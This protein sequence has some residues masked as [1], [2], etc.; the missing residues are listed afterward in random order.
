MTIAPSA[1]MDEL[2]KRSRARTARRPQSP[3]DYLAAM[4]A[5]LARLPL[6]K[7]MAIL[8]EAIRRVDRSVEAVRNWAAGGGDL[9]S[10]S[11]FTLHQ[12]YM[13]ALEFSRRLAAS[14]DEERATP[15][16]HVAATAARAA[17]ALI[18]AGNVAV[19]CALLAHSLIV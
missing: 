1:Q 16:R 14:R 10:P 2:A 13:L 6:A 4:D 8:E 19:T 3:A 12:L 5:A 15:V 11:D 17:V 7:R 18:L 9:P